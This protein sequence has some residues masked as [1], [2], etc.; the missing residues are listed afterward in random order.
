MRWDVNRKL[1]LNLQYVKRNI[2]YRVYLKT[3]ITSNNKFL[4]KVGC[5]L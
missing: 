2:I 5:A 3:R 1:S 4:G